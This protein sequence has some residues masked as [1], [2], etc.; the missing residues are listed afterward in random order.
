MGDSGIAM[1]QEGARW[2]KPTG[3]QYKSDL[4]VAWLFLPALVILPLLAAAAVAW[5]MKCAFFSG[6]YLMILTPLLGG[7]AIGV[8]LLSLVARMHC[9]NWYLAGIVGISQGSWAI[10]AIMTS[11]C[12]RRCPLEWSSGPTCCRG[13]SHSA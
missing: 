4:G 12:L 6:W 2:L 9:R 8:V 1:I 11:A 7:G 13:T 10:S 3:E 5:A